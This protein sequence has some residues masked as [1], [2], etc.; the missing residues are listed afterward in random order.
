MV[1]LTVP[2]NLGTMGAAGMHDVA[3]QIAAS[4]HDER[5]DTGPGSATNAGIISSMAQV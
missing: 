2:M 5:T 1:R 3:H 4:G